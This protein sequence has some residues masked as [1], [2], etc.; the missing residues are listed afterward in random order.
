MQLSIIVRLPVLVSIEGI[1]ARCN[2]RKEY[3]VCS[4]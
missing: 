2:A 3:E 4:G 1:L